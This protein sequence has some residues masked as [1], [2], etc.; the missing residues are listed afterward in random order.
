MFKKIILEWLADEDG[1]E[2]YM[3]FLKNLLNG[4]MQAFETDLAHILQRTMSM[5]DAAISP[6]A[7][8]H[9]FMIGLTA[10]LYGHSNYETVSNREAGYGRYDFM[11]YSRD[12]EKF[13]I[14]FEFK[15]VEL[16]RQKNKPHL[17]KL[18]KSA[19]EALSQIEQQ[20]YFLEAKQRG[21]KRILK[22]GIAFSGKRFGMA[23]E[24]D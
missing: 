22:I 12:P 13:T 24:E 5:H 6:E 9:G 2:W 7:F 3:V 15:K 20:A 17:D 21:A 4:N 19:T 18:K 1:L 10:S 11:I 8:Y 14:L 23:Y 16:P